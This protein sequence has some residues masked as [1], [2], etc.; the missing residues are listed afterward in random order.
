MNLWLLDE[1]AGGFYNVCCI[2]HVIPAT[3]GGTSTE[4]NGVATFVAYNYN[5]GNNLGAN[6]YLFLHGLPTFRYWEYHRRLTPEIAQMIVHNSQIQPSDYSFNQA[7]MN[8]ICGVWW[9]SYDD[10]EKYKRDD[11]YYAASTLKRLEKWRQSA[12]AESVGSLESRNL[13][14][15]M[16]TPDQDLLLSLR[17][18]K[19]VIKIKELMQEVLPYHKANLE[20]RLAFEAAYD[21]YLDGDIEAFDLVEE[22]LDNPLVSAIVFNQIENNMSLLS[23]PFAPWDNPE[24]LQKYLKGIKSGEDI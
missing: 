11:A 8:L 15:E 12:D 19:S 23:D 16:L 7:I 6:L 2:D 20:A 21:K 5:K 9:L 1:G 22:K 24:E 10:S 3:K 4:D 18:A 14:P 17:E 13:V